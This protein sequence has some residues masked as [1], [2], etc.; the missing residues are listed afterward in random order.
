MLSSAGLELVVYIIASVS[1]TII[2]TRSYLFTRFWE[3]VIPAPKEGKEGNGS[4]AM[5]F[6]T[7]PQCLGA[8]IGFG[9]WILISWY[10]LGAIDPLDVLIYGLLNSIFSKAVGEVIG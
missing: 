3:R 4:T 7:C 8:W 2:I 9:F 1:A 10:R 5:L 6:V